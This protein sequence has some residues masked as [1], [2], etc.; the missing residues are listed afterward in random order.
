MAFCKILINLPNLLRHV[1]IRKYHQQFLFK[2]NHSRVT[3]RLIATEL[4]FPFRDLR[5]EDIQSIDFNIIRKYCLP[6]LPNHILGKAHKFHSYIRIFS[7]YH[8]FDYS[9][10][11][12]KNNLKKENFLI[13]VSICLVNCKFSLKLIPQ[14]PWQCCC[15]YNFVKTR[16]Q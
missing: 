6:F 10:A 11:W 2:R 14:F 16:K 13:I 7:T 3:S 5:L 9:Q 4:L 1:N 15:Y 12:T 8:S